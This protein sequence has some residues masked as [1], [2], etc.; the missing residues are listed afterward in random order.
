MQQPFRK[1][2]DNG[3]GGGRD[4]QAENARLRVDGD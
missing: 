1:C 2:A 3:K 4:V